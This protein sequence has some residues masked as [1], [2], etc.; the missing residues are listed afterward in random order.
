MGNETEL[1]DEYK[2]FMRKLFP[3][4]LPQQKWAQQ[5]CNGNEVN[6]VTLQVVDLE[7]KSK[8]PDFY[9]Q[10]GKFLGPCKNTYRIS[11]KQFFNRLSPE[12]RLFYLGVLPIYASYGWVAEDQKLK[13]KMKSRHIKRYLRNF[14]DGRKKLAK[15]FRQN[16]D[17]YDATYFARQEKYFGDLSADILAKVQALLICFYETY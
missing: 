4:R 10:I 1:K 15:L 11:K 7:L 16:T 2:R 14:R 8:C 3:A 13:E 9:Q 17:S 5:I 6:G 12:K